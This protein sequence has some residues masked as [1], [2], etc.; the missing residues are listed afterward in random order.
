[1]YDGIIYVKAQSGCGDGTTNSN[2]NNVNATKIPVA[3][4]TSFADY[5]RGKA[6]NHRSQGRDNKG[7][8][9]ISLHAL[10]A[11]DTVAAA[12]AAA[13]LAP[14]SSNSASSDSIVLSSSAVRLPSDNDTLRIQSKTLDSFSRE[15]FMEANT[16]L[17]QRLH[18]LEE[19]NKSLDDSVRQAMK[20]VDTSTT[21]HQEQETKIK[22]LEKLLE[23]QQYFLDHQRKIESDQQKQ[24]LQQNQQQQLQKQN[25]IFANVVRVQ[26]QQQQQQLI[27]NQKTRKKTP[28][29]SELTLQEQEQF[30]RRRLEKLQSR[31]QILKQADEQA[32]AAAAVAAKRTAAANTTH[33]LSSSSSSSVH[34]QERMP[35]PSLYTTQL[36][37]KLNKERLSIQHQLSQAN[38]MQ[39]NIESERLRIQHQL[40]Q[41]NTVKENIE[42]HTTPNDEPKVKPKSDS[43][44]NSIRSYSSLNNKETQSQS[45]P[46]PQP[47]PERVASRNND[48]DKRKELTTNS[49]SDVKAAKPIE[50][51]SE[52]STKTYSTSG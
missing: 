25:E 2:A 42:N 29:Y 10:T 38:T 16:I 20:L 35:S 33:P 41:A 11:N 46:P 39:D 7:I 47:Q 48:I 43:D 18:D 4:S 32:E 51:Y 40:S 9:P 26:Q 12:A 1:M 19:T 49:N 37:K 36:Q 14:R 21:K 30:K 45:Q 34:Q 13:S 6:A 23:R 44:L 22:Y 28:R 3:T 15:Y 50:T 17:Y 5:L 27:Q 8:V 24:Q 52:I 31:V